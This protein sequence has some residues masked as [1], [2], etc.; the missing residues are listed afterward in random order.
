[1]GHVWDAKTDREVV[2]RREWERF[3]SGKIILWKIIRIYGF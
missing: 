2:K 1:M 3:V